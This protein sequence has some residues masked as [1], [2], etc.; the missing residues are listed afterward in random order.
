MPIAEAL[1]AIMGMGAVIGA[2]GL[3]AWHKQEMTKIAARA[4]PSGGEEVKAAIDD[5]RRE[6]ADLRDTATRYDMS[7]DTAR[8]R[9]ESRLG[10]VESRVQQIESADVPAIGRE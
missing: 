7:F 8:Q 9:L 10:H 6:V 3:I 5:L 4:R 1:V 2:M